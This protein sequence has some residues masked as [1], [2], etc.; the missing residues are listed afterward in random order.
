M[1]FLTPVPLMMCLHGCA[2]EKPHC[3]TILFYH[4]HNRFFFLHDFDRDKCV[5]KIKSP[6][7][8]LC[9]H[10]S[11]TCLPQEYDCS[12]ITVRHGILCSVDPRTSKNS[13]E[14]GHGV[15]PEGVNPGSFFL[16]ACRSDACLSASP[17]HLYDD[18]IA[19]MCVV[20]V[21]VHLWSNRWAS[22]CTRADVSY[23]VKCA[24]V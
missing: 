1:L 9:V 2:S 3:V 18:L 6:G 16:P 11:H 7:F 19:C 22:T 21:R 12:N 4:V 10:H 24:D 23:L 13:S 5:K 17:S 15:A 20:C 14:Y 8:L